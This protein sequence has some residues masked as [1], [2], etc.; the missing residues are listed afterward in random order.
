VLAQ[1]KK[2]TVY[3]GI[4]LDFPYLQEF[5]VS[6]SLKDNMLCF[7]FLIVVPV[8]IYYIGPWLIRAMEWRRMLATLGI[9]FGI[10]GVGLPLRN[11]PT[12]ESIGRLGKRRFW[13]IGIATLLCLFGLIIVWSDVIEDNWLK[14]ILHSWI[15]GIWGGILLPMLF[16]EEIAKRLRNQKQSV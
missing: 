7:I 16:H 9:F 10:V 4:L 5:R 15:G 8:V 2:T 3:L 12:M 11:I 1:N 6:K 14:W 13:V